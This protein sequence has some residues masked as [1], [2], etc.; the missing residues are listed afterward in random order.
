MIATRAIATWR[1]HR[2][3]CK[4]QLAWLRL[5]SSC[6]LRPPGERIGRRARVQLRSSKTEDPRGGSASDCDGG[7]FLLTSY[8]LLV[9]TFANENLTHPPSFGLFLPPFPTQ[10]R[11]K[12]ANAIIE[13][14]TFLFDQMGT[15]ESEA[16][17]ENG[18]DGLRRRQHL[19]LKVA[20]VPNL[21]T[22]E[23]QHRR[24]LEVG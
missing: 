16:A 4:L 22:N 6:C 1:H 3:R 14:S 13:F 15:H 10:L 12:L 11:H 19:L 24:R 8:F 20:N 18:G 5:S 23:P 2:A 9:K 17:S 21:F 7:A